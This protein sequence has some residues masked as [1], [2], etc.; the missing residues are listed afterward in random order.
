M[1][2]IIVGAVLL[3]VAL[4]AML[5]RYGRI[6]ANPAFLLLVYYFFNYP[7]RAYLLVAY[8]ERFNDYSFTD[9][10]I[11]AGLGYSSA[12]V[13]IF[14]GAYLLMLNEFRVRFDFTSLRERP[15]DARLFFLAAFAVLLS[16]AIKIGYELQVGGSFA[17]AGNIEELRR[18]FWVNLMSVPYA[19]KWFA[20]CLGALLWLNSRRL[21]IG[22]ATGLLLGLALLEA[23]LSTGKGTVVTFLILFLFLDNLMTGRAYRVSVLAIGALAAV[24]FSAYSYYA[25]YGG[26]IGLE[27]A[28]DY[29]DFFQA[30]LQKDIPAIVDAQIQ[31]VVDRATYYL[32]ALLLMVRTHASAGSG[33]YQLGSLVELANL[34]PRAFGIVEQ[35]SFDRFVTQAVWGKLGFSQVFIG[36]IGESF[37]V[38]GYGGLVYALVYSGIFAVVAGRWARLSRSAAGISLYFALL[39]GW[40]YQD[41]SLT[42]QLKNLIAI[43]TCYTVAKLAVRLRLWGAPRSAAARAPS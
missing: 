35:Y 25:R 37:F 13:L 17:L 41:A 27:S 9:S 22:L 43:L 42:Y 34:V 11:L 24:L 8:P 28:R 31:N 26:G 33:P 30:F 18:P 5:A 16:G 38:L 12:F 10:E 19:L 1:T 14:V 36:R 32:D 20:I 15:L 3:Y 40:L 29:L 7:V 2:S 39:A 4:A 21:A 6:W 23:F